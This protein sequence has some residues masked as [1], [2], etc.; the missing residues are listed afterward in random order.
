MSRVQSWDQ[1]IWGHTAAAHDS[2]IAFKVVSF[3]D[4]NWL[5]WLYLEFLNGITDEHLLCLSTY[6][7]KLCGTSV[8]WNT[9]ESTDLA[10]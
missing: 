10:N 3:S 4:G 8:P 2:L 9:P 7:L 5:A 6:L 1:K